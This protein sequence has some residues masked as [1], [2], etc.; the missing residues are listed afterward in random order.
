MTNWNTV[1]Q[2]NKAR[3]ANTN[4]EK[5]RA[6]MCNLT[7]FKLNKILSGLTGNCKKQCPPNSAFER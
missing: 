6:V 3:N 2:K 5:Q 7:I 4:Y 1:R